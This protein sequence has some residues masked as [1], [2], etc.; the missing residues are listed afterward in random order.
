MLHTPGFRE[1]LSD[2]SF[3]HDGLGG[4]VGFADR[5]HQIGFGYITN[6]LRQGDT[7]H[8]SWFKLVAK[9]RSLLD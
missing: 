7:E 8:V 5:K 1:F 2:A 6:L 9:V 3:G 4:Q